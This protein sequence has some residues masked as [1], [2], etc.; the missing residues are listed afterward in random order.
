MSNPGHRHSHSLKQ[1][2]DLETVDENRSSGDNGTT[3]QSDSTAST[4]SATTPTSPITPVTPNTKT[5]TPVVAGGSSGPA[6]D[7]STTATGDNS[8][9]QPTRGAVP[10]FTFMGGTPGPPNIM[11][12]SPTTAAGGSSAPAGNLPTAGGSP[13]AS[14]PGSA[15]RLLIIPMVPRRDRRLP[16]PAEHHLRQ[17]LTASVLN[18]TVV[19]R[20]PETS[21]VEALPTADELTQEKTSWLYQLNCEN[22]KHFLELIF[23]LP[24]P[25]RLAQRGNEEKAVATPGRRRTSP[26]RDWPGPALL[27]T[28]R[29][30]HEEG[31]V[32]LYKHNTFSVHYFARK[33]QGHVLE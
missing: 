4:S 2:P 15:G 9:T 17:G 30:L 6:R 20:H 22:R 5:T 29:A 33:I 19:Y 8:R 23:V 26:P 16:H 1:P 27:R 3:D 14:L 24:H 21:K 12:R 11:I 25:I 28:C 32:L 18:A 31:R 10:V 7:S 13:L